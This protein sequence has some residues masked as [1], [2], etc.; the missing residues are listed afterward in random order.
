MS[1][2][3]TPKLRHRIA[4]VFALCCILLTLFACEAERR[5]SDAELGLT[6]QQA[7]GRHLYD[8]YCDRCHAP[9]S[10]RNRQGPS[11]KRVFKKQYFSGS[12]MPAN[13]GRAAE[14]IR[15]GRDKMPS[16]GQVLTQEQINDLLAYLHT[17]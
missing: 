8:Q 1:S 7:S 4:G 13:D 17:L 11:L 6:P 3:L 2:L 15:Y 10:S 14:I 9:Y 12:G 5:R 16:Y